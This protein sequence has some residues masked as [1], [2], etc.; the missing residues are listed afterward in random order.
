MDTLLV[1]R[2]PYEDF[3]P[4]SAGKTRALAFH[5]SHK[6]IAATLSFTNFLVTIFSVLGSVARNN[7]IMA[8]HLLVALQSTQMRNG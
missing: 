7:V 6:M 5:E 8:L 1:T 3:I 2:M 4:F